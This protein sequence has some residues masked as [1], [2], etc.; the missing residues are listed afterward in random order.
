MQSRT[1]ICISLSLYI[2]IYILIRTSQVL[3]LK[4]DYIFVR[5]CVRPSFYLGTLL[6]STGCVLR[7]WYL[8]HSAAV[9]VYLT[10][11]LVKIDVNEP[12]MLKVWERGT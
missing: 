4:G 11:A 5:A 12:R 6:L 10:F 9:G 2:Y 8:H 1:K 3:E 7:A